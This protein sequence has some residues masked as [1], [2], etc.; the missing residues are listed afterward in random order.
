MDR[1][2]HGLGKTVGRFLIL[3]YLDR[4]FHLERATDHGEARKRAKELERDEECRIEII[5]EEDL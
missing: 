2:K 4:G 1:N 3:Q 5:R